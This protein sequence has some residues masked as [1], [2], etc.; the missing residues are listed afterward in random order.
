MTCLRQTLAI[1]AAA[2]VLSA[3]TPSAAQPERVS[4]PNFPDYLAMAERIT[5][6]SLREMRYCELLFIGGNPAGGDLKAELFNSSFLNNK[7]DALD[8]C[9]QALWDKVDADRLKS[10]FGGLKVF[11]NGPRMWVL[12]TVEI[13]ISLKVDNLDGIDMRWFMTVKIP[14]GVNLGEN[15]AYKPMI[16]NRDSVYTFKRDQPVFLLVS[17]DGMPWVMQAMSM[18]VDPTLTY[19]DLET[20]GDKLQLPQGWKYQV[21]VLDRDLNVQAING[22]AKIIQDDLQKPMG[23]PPVAIYLN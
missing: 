7:T 12:D 4:T 9:P 10:Q 11:K 6:D 19:A 23:N 8:T 21:R 20:L 22:K 16:G 5:M 3:A 2:A 1:L 18:I 15:T 17:P 13:P 14:K